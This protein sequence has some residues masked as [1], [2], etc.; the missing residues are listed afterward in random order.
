MC[1]G[2][3]VELGCVQVVKWTWMCAGGEVEL[4]CVQLVKWTWMCAGGE[5]K[6]GVSS[7]HDYIFIYSGH[8]GQNF[9]WKIR[10]ACY[11]IALILYG[12][13]RY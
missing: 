7:V 8:P 10:E 9:D 4:G 6:L 5:V 13:R 1:A 3:E 2:G 12:L 11:W